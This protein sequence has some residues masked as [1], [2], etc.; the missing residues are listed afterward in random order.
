MNSTK[1]A[2]STHRHVLAF[3]SDLSFKTD[4]DFNIDLYS[5]TTMLNDGHT[6]W[7]PN[8]YNVYVGILSWKS[9]AD[10][11]PPALRT[12]FPRPLPSSVT[13]CMLFRTRSSLCLSWGYELP[14]SCCSRWLMSPADELHLV[15]Q[16]D[17]LQLAA[18]C[19]REG[20]VY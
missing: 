20:S 4:Y 5:F 11:F 9:L 2:V 14:S 15:L 19:W 17:R 7:F 13:R 12:C 3:S 10:A 18:T 8:C 6:R 1:Y 16:V